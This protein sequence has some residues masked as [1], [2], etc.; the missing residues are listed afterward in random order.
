M[1]RHLLALLLAWSLALFA[2]PY[3]GHARD[4]PAGCSAPIQV[5]EGWTMATP[6]DAG[7]DLVHHG[8]LVVERYKGTDYRPSIG[9]SDAVEYY[10]SPSA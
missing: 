1:N 5:D 8:K 6:K 7:F 4:V 9:R 10:R 3:A 2:S